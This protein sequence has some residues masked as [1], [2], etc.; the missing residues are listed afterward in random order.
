ML[1]RVF[2]GNIPPLKHTSQGLTFLLGGFIGACYAISEI[3]GLAALSRTLDMN[4]LSYFT[5][6]LRPADGAEYAW[7]G[8]LIGQPISS[9]WYWCVDQ[10]RDGPLLS[11][12]MSSNTL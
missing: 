2:V 7:T 5:S 3:G 8:L 10:V 6:T 12:S 11:G 9:F 1:S 4:G